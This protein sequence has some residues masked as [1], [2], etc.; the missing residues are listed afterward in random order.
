[1]ASL[2][3]AIGPAAWLAAL[4]LSLG[5]AL[6]AAAHEVRPA[7]LELTESAPGRF[8]AIWKQP[9]QGDR[10]LR[11]DPVLPSHC[12]A[13]ERR[14]SRTPDGALV[15]QW[16]YDC[17]TTGIRGHA[18]TIAGLERTL[19]DTFVRVRFQ[20]GETLARLLR[21]ESP[22]LDLSEQGAPLFDYLRLG[23]EHLLLGL[24]HILF[25]IGLAFLVRTP[26]LLVKTVTAFT[27]AHSFTLALSAL[28]VVRLPQAPVEAVIAL[29]IL[30]V[31]VELLR[32]TAKS[33]ANPWRIAFLF[34][35]LHGFGFAG[36]LREIG[37][38]SDALAWAL[39]LFNL[40]V[41]IGQLL[42]V[43]GIFGLVALVTRLKLALPVWSL[44]IPV[45]AMGIIA[46]Y[47]FWDRVT[48]LGA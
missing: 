2:G 43:A 16:E 1:M 46:S 26:W 23:V 15:E 47:W 18:L 27:L 37:L 9:M 39:L 22:S 21:P 4:A 20:D 48:K 38:P 36:A 10:L 13:G 24:D 11:I 3:V 7:Y 6:T 19:T 25:V 17:G 5:G 34:G 12:A 44:R 14:A 32:G 29:S 40:G 41:E 35:L 28:D 42:V 8:Q 33:L 30:Y 31:A 45:Y